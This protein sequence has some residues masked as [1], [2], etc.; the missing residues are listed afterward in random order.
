[1][2]VLRK[3]WKDKRR[4]VIT[5]WLIFK[6]NVRKEEF[7]LVRSLSLSSPLWQGRKNGEQLSSLCSQKGNKKKWVLTTFFLQ[8]TPQNCKDHIEMG[9]YFLFNKCLCKC[10]P[11]CPG[12][13]SPVILNWAVNNKWK[14]QIPIPSYAYTYAIWVSRQCFCCLPASSRPMGP[15]N[16]ILEWSK[17]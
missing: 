2:G 1:M 3:G 16:H 9:S 13:L 17:Q 4:G 8:P 12:I 14:S 7:T 11:T 10:H 5:F 6:N 15:F